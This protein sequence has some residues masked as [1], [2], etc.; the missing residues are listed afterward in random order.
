PVRALRLKGA[1]VARMRLTRTIIGFAAGASLTLTP[2]Y[3]GS[4]GRS[5]NVKPTTVSGKP[6][7]TP[8]GKS[9][10]G[11]S[12]TAHTAKIGKQT[13]K[14]VIKSKTTTASAGG[15]STTKTTTKTTT[16]TTPNTTTPLNPIARKISSKPNL[17]AKIT[18]M[19]P[20]GADG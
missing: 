16:T 13:T 9:T 5:S 17:N 18:A 6:A 19:L 12:T 11:K 2:V 15:T 7:A 14:S 8:S 20:V 10:K 4:H 3:A 1:E